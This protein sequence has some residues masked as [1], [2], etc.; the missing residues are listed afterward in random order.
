MT[1]RLSEE[2]AVTMPFTETDIGGTNTAGGD[3]AVHW[4]SMIGFKRALVY[5][6]LGTWNGTDDLDTAKI[7]QASDSS[8][9]G[10]KDL[11]TSASGGDY[12]TDAPIDAD[13]DFIIFDFRAEDLDVANGFTHFRFYGA[14]AGNTGVDNISC[15]Y[16]RESQVARKQ[17]TAAASAGSKVYV[18]P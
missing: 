7:E 17:L 16:I 2:L 5:V 1:A 15:V 6:E 14:E 8:G 13:G 3:D 10:K 12:D 18:T 11:T 9:T 4:A